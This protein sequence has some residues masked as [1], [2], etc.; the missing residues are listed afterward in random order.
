MF[1]DGIKQARMIFL[2][3]VCQ[4]KKGLCDEP[5]SVFNDTVIRA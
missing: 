3:T 2:M 4:R 1:I 5:Q